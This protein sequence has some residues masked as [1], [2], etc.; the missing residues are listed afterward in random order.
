[1]ARISWS[2]IGLGIVL[3]SASISNAQNYPTRP[4]NV[5]VP[6]PPGAGTDGVT[7]VVLEGMSANLQ[8]PMIVENKPG[9]A[10]SIGLAGLGRADADGYTIAMTNNPPITANMFLQKSFPYDPEKAFAPI[11]VVADTVIILAV[12]PSLPVHSVAELVDYG[13]RNPGKLTFGS[14]GIGSAHHVAGELM[15]Q[16]GGIHMTHVPYRG[17]SALLQDLV[18]GAINVG[19]GTPTALVPLADA[20]SVRILALAEKK[21]SPDFPN[22]PTI[23]ETLPGVVTVTWL[24]LLSPAATPKPIV[25]RVHQA[26]MA[27]LKSPGMAEKMRRIGW[28]PV[29]SSPEEFAALIK[30]E[31]GY[32]GKVLPSIGIVPQ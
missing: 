24:G 25:S 7:R 21:R 15:N 3:M 2:L 31:T 28:N 32:W 1:M 17:T 26:L 5:V 23:V 30:E 27:S 4:I 6:F 19:F 22:V 13:K 10:G 20:G 29:G 11:S 8:Q 14:A 12:N 9:A 18:S 16:K